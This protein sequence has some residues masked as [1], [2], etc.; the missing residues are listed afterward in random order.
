MFGKIENVLREGW[1]TLGNYS[2]YPVAYCS[3]W[4]AAKKAQAKAIEADAERYLDSLYMIVNGYEP[5]YFEDG[6][7]IIA[8]LQATPRQI[9]E[10]A[11][12]T[13]KG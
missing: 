3:H 2:T 4:M 13:L 9:A 10:A 11:Y 7:E 1:I 12:L 8:L 5:E 6:N